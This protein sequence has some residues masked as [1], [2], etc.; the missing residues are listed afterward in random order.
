MSYIKIAVTILCTNLTW[1]LA[2]QHV[3]KFNTTLTSYSIKQKII[4]S[5]N[6]TTI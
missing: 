3:L 4:V 6:H 1:I 5:F 2:I